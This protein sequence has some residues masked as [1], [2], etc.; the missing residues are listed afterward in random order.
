MANILNDGSMTEKVVVTGIGLFTPMA[1]GTWR[2]VAA[3]MYNRT[4]FSEHPTVLVADDAYG[5]VLRGATVS[6]VTSSFDRYGF[7]AAELACALL[8]PAI[9]ECLSGLVKA[10]SNC[11]NLRIVNGLCRD[12]SVFSQLLRKNFPDLVVRARVTDVAGEQPAGHSFLEQVIQAVDALCTP[13][14]DHS[15]ALVAAV[16]SLCFPPVLEALMM[17]DRLLSGSNPEGII[18]GE[19][20]G[21][22]LLEREQ[23]AIRRGAPVYGRLNSYGRGT[24]PVPRGNS[25]PSSARGLTDAFRQA[26]EGRRPEAAGISIVVGDLNGE[27]QRALEWSLAESRVFSNLA[28]GSGTLWLPAFTSGDCG[29]AMGAV[30]SVAALGVLAK[31]AAGGED[32]AV[33]F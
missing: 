18:A 27:R 24:D 5:T 14:C 7:G 28:G 32:A 30:Q 21:V 25:R 19:A 9:R 3:L 15:A 20:A 6:R 23:D 26:V 13:R 10:P 17:S 11:L 4:C 16:D 12:W 31:G 33:F 1:A 29:L 22:I 8:A 2:S